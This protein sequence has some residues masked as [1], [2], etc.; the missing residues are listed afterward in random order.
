MFG[1]RLLQC[2]LNSLTE[3]RISPSGVKSMDVIP[4]KRNYVL[5]V[6]SYSNDEI[7]GAAIVVLIRLN[8]RIDSRI[9]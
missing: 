5:N 3:Y 7:L 2:R 6:V 4:D 8:T 9:E 1:M